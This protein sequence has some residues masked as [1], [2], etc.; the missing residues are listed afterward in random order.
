MDPATEQRIRAAYAAFVDADFDTLNDFFHPDAVYVNPPYAVESGTRQGRQ[1][2]TE[3]WRGRAVSLAWFA[4]RE[5][6]LRAAGLA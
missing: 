4:T 5:E 3:V 6:G 1:Q 2:L